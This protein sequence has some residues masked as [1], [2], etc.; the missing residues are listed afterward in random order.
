MQQQQQ[1]K[2]KFEFI[3]LIAVGIRVN[4]END[5]SLIAITLH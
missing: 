2:R 3:D 5:K 1:K 4:A